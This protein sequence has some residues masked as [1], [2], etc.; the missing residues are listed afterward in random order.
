MRPE[1][2]DNLSRAWDS[3]LPFAEERE[4]M[5][6]AVSDS[7]TVANL[8]AS[9]HFYGTVRISGG[10]QSKLVARNFILPVNSF[11]FLSLSLSLFSIISLS[12]TCPSLL[13]LTRITTPTQRDARQST[14]PTRLARSR[15]PPH[16]ELRLIPDSIIDLHDKILTRNVTTVGL[17]RRSEILSS[18]SLIVSDGFFERSHHWQDWK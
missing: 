3:T 14:A 7:E 16:D 8:F 18:G 9:C 1:E 10:R 5:R 13:S 15:V 11:P 4:E 6:P 2:R 12:S 17:R